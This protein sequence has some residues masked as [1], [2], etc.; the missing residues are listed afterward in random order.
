MIKDSACANIEKSVWDKCVWKWLPAAPKITTLFA[1]SSS[2]NLVLLTGR[3]GC[4]H[5]H[6]FEQKTKTKKT[7]KQRRRNTIE[8]SLIKG[9]SISSVLLKE[10]TKRKLQSQ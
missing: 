6:D 7:I 2:S 8:L 5:I 9:S 4:I 3:N 1:S 10:R